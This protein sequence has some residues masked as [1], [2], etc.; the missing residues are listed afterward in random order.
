ML[1]TLALLALAAS[2]AHATHVCLPDMFTTDEVTFDPAKEEMFGTKVF[3]AKAWGKQRM[4]IDAIVLDGKLITE[5]KQFLF[6]FSRK[7]WYEISKNISS[8]TETC[9][10]HPLA[11]EIKAPCLAKNA[12]HRGT[13]TLGGTLACDNFREEVIDHKG[14]TTRVD[15]LMAAH[16]NVPVRAAMRVGDGAKGYYVDEYWNW[17]NSVQ[18]DNFVVPSICQN[19]E[20]LKE[21]PRTVQQIMKPLRPNS[22]LW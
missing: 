6:D 5:R 21:E 1:Y 10:Q 9:H 3:F 2:V 11:G 19:A 18:H 8:H 20:M 22:A 14:V 13:V 4:D 16:I 7:V 15:V 12:R 17:E